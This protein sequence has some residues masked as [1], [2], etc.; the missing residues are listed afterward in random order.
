MKSYNE[1]LNES[2]EKKSNSSSKTEG[3]TSLVDSLRSWGEKYD[4][5]TRHFVWEHLNTPR[6]K[7]LMNKILRNPKTTYTNS[8]F[9]KLVE[10]K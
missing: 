6:G 3:I 10:K 2:K 4:I 8:E 7:E 1:F 9:V 5:S